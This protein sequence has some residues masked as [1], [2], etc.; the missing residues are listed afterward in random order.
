MLNCLVISLRVLKLESVGL[1]VTLV[2]GFE[3][4]LNDV[5]NF[6]IENE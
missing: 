3:N 4:E 6:K 2:L 1:Y 5:T